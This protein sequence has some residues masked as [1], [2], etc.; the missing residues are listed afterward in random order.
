MGRDPRTKGVELYGR[1]IWRNL[2]KCASL[3]PAHQIKYL[4][5]EREMQPNSAV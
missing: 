1:K 5:L 4:S 2:V 3:V